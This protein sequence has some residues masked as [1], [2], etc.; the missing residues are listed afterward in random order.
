MYPQTI[1]YFQFVHHCLNGNEL[2]YLVIG[3][4]H[5]D[6]QFNRLALL[7]AF[8]G[9]FFCFLLRRVSVPSLVFHDDIGNLINSEFFFDST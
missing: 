1:E 2:R 8:W 6:C 3:G 4:S 7:R 9:C 5:F